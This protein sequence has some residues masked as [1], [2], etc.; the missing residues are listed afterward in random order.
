[1]QAEHRG[2]A[3]LTVGHNQTKPVST[4]EPS[5]SPQPHHLCNQLF[6]PHA[7]SH[8]EQD[9]SGKGVSLRSLD[10]G[11]RTQGS[12]PQASS[13]ADVWTQGWL[14]W[15]WRPEVERTHSPGTKP[16]PS[17][18]PTGSWAFS[19]FTTR[20]V[21]VISVRKEAS[22]WP[23]LGSELFWGL[24]YPS[25]PHRPAG[26]KEPRVREDFQGSGRA[27]LQKLFCDYLLGC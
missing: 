8:R 2:R 27:G 19:A 18:C 16:L 24:C 17:L 15:P 3:L 1:M 4:G 12:S 22:P 21:T 5:A 11:W 25:S 20:W 26:L 10:L 7:A 9:H 14:C 6:A 23:H 13:T